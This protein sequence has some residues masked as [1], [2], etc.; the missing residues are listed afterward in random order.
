MRFLDQEHSDINQVGKKGIVSRTPYSERN[1]MCDRF[2]DM[3]I[4][5]NGNFIE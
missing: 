3:Q 2:I 1:A 4:D 5:D